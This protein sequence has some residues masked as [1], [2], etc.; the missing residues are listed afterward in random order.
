MQRLN[1]NLNSLIEEFKR[2]LNNNVQVFVFD[3]D[4]EA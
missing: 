3:N 2:A 1:V 4:D